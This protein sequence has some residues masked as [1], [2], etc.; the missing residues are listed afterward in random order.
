M[1]KLKPKSLVSPMDDAW[2]IIKMVA[3]YETRNEIWDVFGHCYNNLVKTQALN[4]LVGDD[5]VYYD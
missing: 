3:R 4:I 5:V 1:N 2:G